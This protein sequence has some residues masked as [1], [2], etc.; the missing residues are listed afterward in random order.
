MDP[1]LNFVNVTVESDLAH[2]TSI[3]DVSFSL[4]PGD[5]ALVRLEMSQQRLPLADVA[6][7]L[8]EP[9]GGQVSFMGQDWQKMDHRTAASARGKIGRIF[10]AAGWISNLNVDENLYL[11][12]RQHTDQTDEALAQQASQIARMFGL[13]GI[14]RDR[15]HQI[16]PTDLQRA[17]CVRA[18]LGKPKLLILERPTSLVSLDILPPL[19]NAVRNAR[20]GGAAVLWLTEDQMVWKD[21]ACRPTHKFMMAGSNMVREVDAPEPAPKGE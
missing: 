7:G 10:G 19:V 20:A 4:T 18:F 8:L 2:D 15:P 11:A 1:I 9:T 6:Q 12:A 17:A 14:P 13:P 5:L 3:W 16:R 21:S